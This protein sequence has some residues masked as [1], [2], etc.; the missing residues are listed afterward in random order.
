GPSGEE[1]E[2][3][4]RSVTGG[5]PLRIDSNRKLLGYLATIGF[6]G[7]PL[8]YLDRFNAQIDAVTLEQVRAALA[9][10]LAPDRLVTVTVGPAAP[11]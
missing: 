5:F 10:R 6:Y 8:D 1:L 2:F 7:L 3:A 4:R 11:G 9:R